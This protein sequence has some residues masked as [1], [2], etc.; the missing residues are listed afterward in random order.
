MD[1]WRVVTA[2]I[3]GAAFLAL[4]T[5]A[6]ADPA[7]VPNGPA[8]KPVTAADLPRL[9]VELAAVTAHA[10]QLAAALDAEAGR[11]GGLHVAM[12]R[13]A[14][15]H[16]GAQARL[17]AR[18]RA[19]FI[20]NVPDP[21]G[22]VL[23]RLREP[24]LRRIL[25]QG[26][27]ASVAVDRTLVD[28][29]TRQSGQVAV[30]RARAQAYRTRLLGQA[31]GV[32][33]AQDR[34]RALLATA[35][36]LANQLAAE[37]AAREQALLAVQRAALD[38]VSAT[39][40]R[41]LTPAQTVRSQRAL[42]AQGAVLA[43][44]EAAG[45]NYPAGYGPTGQVLSGT[46]SWYGPGFVGNPTASGAPYDPERLTCANKEL[47]LGTVIRVSANGRAVSCL[48]NDRG[49]YVGDRILDMSR[50]GA[51]ALGYDGLAQVVIEVLQPAAPG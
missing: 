16:D 51:R 4:P 11:D 9:Q 14:E 12:D 44:V 28:D 43:A 27:A 39:V 33:A 6:R 45:L 1:P 8:A 17:D 41:T 22:E 32:L 13:L 19:V 37:A 15:Q 46:A 35:Q 36:T 34:A 38:Q 2:G 49:P 24:G 21:L 47:P 31:G 10:G 7:P 50:A 26:R 5:A 23:T 42:A 29:L 25:D 30:L 20:S 40:T 18:V 48:V 3:L